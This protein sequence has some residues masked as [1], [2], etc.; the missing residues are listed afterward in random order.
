MYLAAGQL[1]ARLT[2]K[3]WDEVMRDRIFRPLGMASSNTSVTGLGRLPNVA[4]PHLEVN[5]TV[6]IIPRFNLD[7]VGPAGSINSNAL[8]MASGCASNWL[9]A[10]PAASS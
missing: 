4:T 5:D 6:R 9:G 2:G 3:S 7:N 8:E 1:T 10:R